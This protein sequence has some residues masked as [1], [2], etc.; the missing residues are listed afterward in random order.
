VNQSQKFLFYMIM[1]ANIFHSILFE[2]PDDRSKNDKAEAPVFFGDLNC[3]QIVDGITADAKDYNLKSFFYTPLQRVG[4]IEYRHEI[5]RDLEHPS[6]AEKVNSFTREMRKMRAHLALIKKVSYKEE[7]QIL[8]LESVEIYCEAV[9]AL[10]D[11]LSSLSLDLNS[12]GFSGF[13][14]YLKQ[15]IGTNQYVSLFS[16]TK[17]LK[18]A[19]SEI[20]YIVRLYDGKGRFT[21]R[22]YENEPDY[23]PE[24]E[25]IFRKFESGIAAIDEPD[26]GYAKS[27]NHIEAKILEFVA[28]LNPDIFGRLDEYCMEN[29]NF[30]DKTVILF[31]R[32]VQFYIGYI[33][34]IA[35]LRGAS[36]Q[37]CYPQVSSKDKEVFDYGAFDLAL[38][39]KLLEENSI[40][41]T[42]DFHLKKGER[43]IVVSGPNQ[44]GKT[45]FARMFGQLHWLASL[46]LP[47][48]GSSAR[49]FLFDKLFTHFE[50]EEAVKDL[51]GKLEDDLIR[52]H[53]I[54]GS[55]T[56]RSVII[57]NEIFS[58]T[59]L[60]DEIYLSKKVMEK[61]SDTDVLC[62]WVTFAA[63]LISLSPKTVSMVSTVETE[64][65]DVRT[66]KIVEKPADGLAYASAI[67]RKYRLTPDLLKTRIQS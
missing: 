14:D 13:R 34:Y 63:E 37:F 64:N 10:A 39:C 11:D 52:I 30:A 22:Q 25:E 54:L 67:A 62:I 12:R 2:N 17:E 3:H 7:K 50:K 44:G 49:L 4:A 51:R 59:T 65:P 28:R 46:G 24:I 15:Y 45:T 60:H 36:L 29:E 53:R 31:D 21:V 32:E 55:V 16:R 40:V 48:P 26:T 38:A 8:F 33:G 27:L 1:T 6:V 18:T 19:L 47:V 41:V 23:S 35:P 61:I 56:P 58:S 20:R 43:I 9:M 42:N 66:F 57:L 5:M